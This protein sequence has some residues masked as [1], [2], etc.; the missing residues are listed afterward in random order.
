M[1]TRAV[2]RVLAQ[3]KESVTGGDIYCFGGAGLANSLMARSL[4]DEYY[5]MVTPQ[6]F[7]DGKRLFGPGLPRLDLALS[8]AKVLDVGSVLL[9]YLPK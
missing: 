8:S 2:L 9:H 5:L 6:L 3:L 7:G 4:V 1:C